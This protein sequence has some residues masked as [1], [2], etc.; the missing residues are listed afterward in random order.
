MQVLSTAQHTP[1]SRD[2]RRRYERYQVR[3]ECWIESDDASV[4]GLAADLG[5]GGLFLRTAVPI[6]QGHRVEIV[7]AFGSG[8]QVLR[9]QG[10]VTRSVRAQ[11]GQRHGVGIELTEIYEGADALA[12]LARPNA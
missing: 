8:T 4:H 2:E 10:V 3:C 5:L 7:I 9:G 12:R 11:R 1:I 6:E